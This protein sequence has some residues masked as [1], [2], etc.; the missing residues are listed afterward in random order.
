MTMLT[1]FVALLISVLSV[2]AL[3]GEHRRAECKVT[4]S[5]AKV[6]SE[7]KPSGMINALIVSGAKAGPTGGGPAQSLPRCV[8]F[9]KPDNNNNP[10][11]DGSVWPYV[12]V[13]DDCDIYLDDSIKESSALRKKGMVSMSKTGHLL[14][15][16]LPVYFYNDDP[17]GEDS[18]RDA[19][20]YC[21]TGPWSSVSSTG[22]GS[23]FKVKFYG[24]DDGDDDDDGDD[25]GE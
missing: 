20:C 25:N 23:A 4:V 8:Y 17:T 24:L 13:D 7:E 5:L 15:G 12:E 6:D 18:L 16:G 10:K 1:S 21:N 19:S 3:P 22:Q 14:V 11:Y 2:A 9:Y